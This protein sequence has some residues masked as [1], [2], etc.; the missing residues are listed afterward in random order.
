MDRMNLP[1]VDLKGYLCDTL[2]SRMTEDLVE[3]SEKTS[4]SPDQYTQVN[5]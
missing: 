1:L 4:S 3:E 2:Q 5:Q